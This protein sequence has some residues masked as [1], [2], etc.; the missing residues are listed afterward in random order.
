MRNECTRETMAKYK[1]TKAMGDL[2]IAFCTYL[3]LPVLH[4]IILNQG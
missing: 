3:L 2:S 4:F 1:M